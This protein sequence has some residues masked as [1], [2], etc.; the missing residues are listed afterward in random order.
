MGFGLF[1]S[2]VSQFSSCSFLR[3]D[4]ARE[5]MQQSTNYNTFAQPK[6]IINQETKNLALKRPQ[7]TSFLPTESGSRYGFSPM[8]TTRFPAR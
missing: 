8:T 6:E 1:V 3:C 4:V 2:W 7:A 5:K